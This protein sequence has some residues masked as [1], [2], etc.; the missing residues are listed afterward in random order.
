MAGYAVIPAAGMSLRM[1]RPKLLLPIGDQPV[2][3]RVLQVMTG[4]PITRCVVVARHH[5]LAVQQL[6]AQYPADLVCP[7]PPPEDMLSSI[8]AGVSFLQQQVAPQSDDGWWVQPAD[9][10][11]VSAALLDRLWQE[12]QQGREAC[13]PVCAGRRGHPLLIRWKYT[14]ALQAIPPGEGLNW[15]FRDQRVVLHH[16]PWD[17]PLSQADLDTPED[18]ARLMQELTVR[19]KIPSQAEGQPHGLS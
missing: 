14:A 18:Y 15:L 13:V 2:L 3:A 1:G 8:R 16:V 17:D 7:E 11:A 19:T 4:P 5:D 12:F 10:P 6:V 9:H